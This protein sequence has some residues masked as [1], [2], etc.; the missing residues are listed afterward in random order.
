MGPFWKF[1]N[2]SR[3]SKDEGFRFFVWVISLYQIFPNPSFWK[4][5]FLFLLGL[6]LG[7]SGGKKTGFHSITVF[8]RCNCWEI[9]RLFGLIGGMQLVLWYQASFEGKIIR[10]FLFF[11]FGFLFW[12][13][14]VE[15]RV[16]FWVC[17]IFF[18]WVR[19]SWGCSWILGRFWGV[20]DWRLWEFGGF[21]WV[22]WWICEKG[23]VFG[24]WLLGF[25]LWKKESF[26]VWF[27]EKFRL[28]GICISF[29]GKYET[30]SMKFRFINFCSGFSFFESFMVCAFMG[31]N[32]KNSENLGVLSWC[33]LENRIFNW[34]NS[35]II[36][37]TSILIFSGIFGFVQGCNQCGY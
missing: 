35:L 31:W 9:S 15:C 13:L 28:L 17:G 4:N 20:L 25:N 11:C 12:D 7:R 29:V 18:F 1:E 3:K 16:L 36:I 8:S 34:L 32:G 10:M 27:L 14:S 24:T 19:L 5:I 26:L 33:L 6:G 21:W 30:E 2:F 37:V 23:W 22:E